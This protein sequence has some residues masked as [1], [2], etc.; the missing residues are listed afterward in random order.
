MNIIKWKNICMQQ[1][2]VCETVVDHVELVWLSTPVVPLLGH[3]ENWL[4]TSTKNQ[5]NTSWFKD[6]VPQKE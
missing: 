6:T 2:C 3:E 4:Q 1:F 5:Q